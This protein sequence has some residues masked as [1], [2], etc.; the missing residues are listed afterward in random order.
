VDKDELRRR[1][2]AQEQILRETAGATDASSAHKRGVALWIM[3]EAFMQLTEFETAAERFG[4]ADSILRGFDTEHILVVSGAGQRAVALLRLGRQPEALD[5]LNELVERVGLNWVDPTGDPH[6]HLA[7]ALGPWLY[8]MEQLGH[9][10]DAYDAADALITAFDPPSSWV[11]ELE[12]AQA[13]RTKGSVALVRGDHQEATELLEEAILRSASGDG[14]GFLTV[15]AEATLTSGALL[16]QTGREI[17]ALTGYDELIAR[18]D[19]KPDPYLRAMV[20][21]A[22]TRRGKLLA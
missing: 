19:N 20:T 5:V 18:C 6:D 12:V 9:A 17:D 16:E 15:W 2:A 21:E 11:R 3:A 14:D 10:D 1:I 4:E 13:F 7:G 22:N 8:L